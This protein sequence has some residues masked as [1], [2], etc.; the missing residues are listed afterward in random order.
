[1]QFAPRNAQKATPP[2]FYPKTK[3]KNHLFGGH[4]GSVPPD[5]PVKKLTK[6]LIW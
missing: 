4:T 1:M 6:P 3:S 2:P 5:P